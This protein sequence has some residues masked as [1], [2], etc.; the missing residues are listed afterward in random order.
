MK[1][2]KP[3]V[4]VETTIPS[5][6]GARPSRDL[7]VAAHQQ[8]TSQWWTTQRVHYWLYVSQFVVD[9][10]SEGAP[11]AVRERLAVLKGLPDLEINE[12]VRSLAGA[13]VRAG[14]IPR[15]KAADAAHVAVAAVHSMDFLLTWNCQHLANARMETAM[16]R[17]C[18][19]QGF[20]CPVICTP[21]QLMEV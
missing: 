19:E 4:Y 17:F 1:P 15:K 10:A 20:S 6:L 13:I 11:D 21:E 7:I 8:I 18:A 3:R 9:E 2:V 5:Y 16:R 14:L 12:E